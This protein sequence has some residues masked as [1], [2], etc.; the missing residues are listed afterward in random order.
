ML[1]TAPP[2]DPGGIAANGFTQAQYILPCPLVIR[3]QYYSQ[4]TDTCALLPAVLTGALPR[5]LFSTAAAGLAHAH[6]I[7]QA[8][9]GVVWGSSPECWL[10]AA[11]AVLSWGSQVVSAACPWLLPLRSAHTTAQHLPVPAATRS[12]LWDRPSCRDADIAAPH[13][14][15]EQHAPVHVREAAAAHQGQWCE[16]P[17]QHCT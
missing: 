11:L 12:C 9:A 2:G 15:C 14:R 7:L 8:H 5:L 16:Q 6:C 3:L 17:W 4:P 1:S 13:P 10:T